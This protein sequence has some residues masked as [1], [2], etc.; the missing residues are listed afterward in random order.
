MIVVIACARHKK[1]EAGHF[2][3]DDERKLMFVA[4]PREA[5]RDPTV[6]YVRP[7]GRADDRWDGEAKW[8]QRV[9]QYDARHPGSDNPFRLLPAG[10]LYANETYALLERRYGLDGFY[11]LSAGWGLIPGD[12]LTPRYDITFDEKADALNRRRMSDPWTDLK[13]FPAK[14]T[15]PVM[16]FGG[17]DYV[18]LFCRLTEGIV[19]PRIVWRGSAE[20]VEAPGC[21]VR[22]YEP[23]TEKNWH[24]ECVRDFLDGKLD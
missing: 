7:D 14:T 13:L 19:A 24:Y 2:R 23:A 22:Q 3:T 21:C 8:W 6:R 15:E 12:F 10:R 17:K 5:P 18:P 16:F 1:P 4:D 20:P 11:I 9:I